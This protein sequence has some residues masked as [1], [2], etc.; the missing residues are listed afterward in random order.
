M[1]SLRGITLQPYFQDRYVT[2]ATEGFRWRVET[3]EAREMPA[4][5]FLHKKVATKLYA[6]GGG[7]A[8]PPEEIEWA[9]EFNGVASPADL[10]D[11]P[12]GEPR[13]DDLP[14]FYRLA[15][16]DQA[17]RSRHAALAAYAA[18]KGQVKALVECLDL[19]DG[20]VPAPPLV[21]GAPPPAPP[22]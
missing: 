11:Y 8:E 1:A 2:G 18:L 6:A 15:A 21:I 19:M 5:I 10:E 20:L 3:V 7:G 14:P 13:A 17:F 22:P 4:A 12:E 16:V 9:G